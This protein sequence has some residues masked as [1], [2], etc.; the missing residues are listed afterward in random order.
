MLAGAMV[1]DPCT[2]FRRAWEE[3]MLEAEKALD[4]GN[5]KSSIVMSHRRAG[6]FRENFQYIACTQRYLST[7]SAWE[8]VW[9]RRAVWSNKL[10]RS[11]L[12]IELNL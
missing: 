1:W 7:L 2:P 11:R 3:S 4:I 8:P 6:I 5:C 12:E 10:E 9:K